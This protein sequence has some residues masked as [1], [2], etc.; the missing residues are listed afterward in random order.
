MMKIL[1][2]ILP[3][4]AHELARTLERAAVR[5]FRFF[6]A[7]FILLSFAGPAFCQDKPESLLGSLAPIMNAIH[8]DRGFPMDFAHKGKLS[9]AEWR[10]RG[11]AEVQRV[12]AY[13]PEKV[14]LDVKVHSVVKR[15]GYEIR[16][17][18][19]AGSP[20][21]RIPAFLLVPE[22]KGPFPGVVALHDHGGWFM[23]GK[24]KLVA[25]EGEHVA[26]KEFRNGSYGGRAW[27]EA[28]A[29]RGFVVIVPD[30][31]YWGDRRLKYD[32]EPEELR[33]RVAG[34]DT[35][36]IEY[37]RA[38]NRYLVERTTDLHI[39]MSF[40]GMTWGGIITYDD[41]RAVDLLS[42]LSE[43]D[44][45]RIG[46]AGLSGGGFRSTYLAGMEP[47]IK[48]AVI[49]GWMT[50]L[51][52]TTDIPYPVHR[53]MFDPF[54]VHANLDHP[55]IAILAAPDCAILVQNC[56]RDRLFTRAGMDAAVN[57]I[58]RVY[59]ELKQP[60][61]FQGRYYDVPHQFNVEMQNDAFEWLERW[62]KKTR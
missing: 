33:N 50:S 30:A 46:C 26:V 57:K 22:G 11:R 17:I 48:A 56:G 5:R 47:R 9:V 35:T 53:D 6:A 19:F 21:Y 51:P 41:R 18:S 42:S 60:D 16:S 13:A 45:E 61:R 59:T 24:E 25:M 20:Y 31:F 49:V 27:A 7:V 36:T 14:S 43:V 55:D 40:A 2:L 37:V 8:E 54:G 44:K 58:A 12:F 4:K 28:L 34:L 62:L 39:R 29:K 52:T 15:D 1:T 32:L 38:V 23:H 3:L 10:N